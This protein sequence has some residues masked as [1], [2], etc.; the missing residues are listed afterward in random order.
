MRSA[1]IYYGAVPAG[2]LA[3]SNEGLYTF[4]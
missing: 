2:I 3:E 4:Q 1:E